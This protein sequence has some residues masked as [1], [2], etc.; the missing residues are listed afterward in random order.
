[1]LGDLISAD[2]ATAFLVY[3]PIRLRVDSE[4][5][6]L[7]GILYVSTHMKRNTVGQKRS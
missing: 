3:N 4:H 2:I 6:L 1:M 5:S 7:N